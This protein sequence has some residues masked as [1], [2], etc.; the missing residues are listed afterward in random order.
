[1]CMGMLTV[2]DI[3]TTGFAVVGE[4]PDPKIQEAQKS[5]FSQMVTWLKE[6]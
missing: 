6:H 3:S 4:Y 1:M 5:A 2:T